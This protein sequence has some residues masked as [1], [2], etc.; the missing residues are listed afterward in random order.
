MKSDSSTC[1][2]GNLRPVENVLEHYF[3]FHASFSW[4][5]AKDFIERERDLF[6]AEHS[7]H[8]SSIMASMLNAMAQLAIVDKNYYTLQFFTSKVFQRKDLYDFYQFEYH[9]LDL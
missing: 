5:Q 8:V 4:D 9:L 2:S 7:S 3:K 6:R 1:G